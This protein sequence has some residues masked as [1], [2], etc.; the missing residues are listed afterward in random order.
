MNIEVETVYLTRFEEYISLFRLQ[1]S[2]ISPYIYH[3]YRM[4]VRIVQ[5]YIYLVIWKLTSYK[6]KFIFS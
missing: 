4:N 6:I 5:K 3:D 2:V 1:Y